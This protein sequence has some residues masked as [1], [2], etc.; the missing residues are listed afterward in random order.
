MSSSSPHRGW[1]SRG[2]L[3]HLDVAN[4]LQAVTFRLA[5]ALPRKVVERWKQEL[6]QQPG[7][8][9]QLLREKIARYEDAGY[10]SCVLK[11]SEVAG[12]VEDALLCFDAERYQMLEWVI[13]PN[14]V[15][16]LIHCLPGFP[17]GDTIR[18]W[19]TYTAR[20]INS[21]M[22]RNGKFWS[23]DYHDR[24]IRDLDHLANVRAYIRNNPVKAGLCKTASDWPWSS[25]AR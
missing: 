15:H 25:A 18:S 19:K 23:S 10:G 11:N 14:H 24:Y 2:Y 12:I 7:T 6:L 4:E 3:P 21:L 17:L 16:I 9:D 22:G 13:M 20:K 5:D 8:A 1:H